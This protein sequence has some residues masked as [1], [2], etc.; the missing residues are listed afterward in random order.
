MSANLSKELRTKY[1]KRSFPIRKG[2]E[3]KVMTGASKK[4]TGKINTINRMK[5]K[6]AIEGL[7]KQKKDGTK[8]NIWFDASNLQIQKLDLGDKKRIKALE[9]KEIKKAEKKEGKIGVKTESKAIPET[10]SNAKEVKKPEK[11][12][13]VKKE[14]K[15]EKKN[16]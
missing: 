3:V 5:K 9:R 7:Q 6:V 15:T 2:D 8:I 16:A 12:K 14:G 11:K 13:E 10:S 1:G 4:K